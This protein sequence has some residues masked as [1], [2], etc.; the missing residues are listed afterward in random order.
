MIRC[1][2]IRSGLLGWM[3]SRVL[4]IK[5]DLLGKIIVKLNGGD[6]IR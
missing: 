5:R 6:G 4:W 3:M 1:L 2:M